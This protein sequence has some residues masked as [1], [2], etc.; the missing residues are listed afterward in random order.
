MAAG[1][2]SPGRVRVEDRQSAVESI[3]AAARSGEEIA[4]SFRIVLPDGQIKWFRARARSD[5]DEEG[6]VFRLSGIFADITAA[7]LAE[8]QADQQRRELAHLTRVAAQGADRG[9]HRPR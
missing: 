8:Q 9:V 4:T 1:Q 5:R 7:K 2:L 6:R 3:R